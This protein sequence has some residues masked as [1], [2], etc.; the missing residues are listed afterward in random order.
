MA[1]WRGFLFCFCFCLL[2]CVCVC[3]CVCV[4]LLFC[5]SGFLK[6]F[7]C[8]FCCCCV[9]VF[10]SSF[11]LCF[12]CTHAFIC[13]LFVSFPPSFFLSFCLYFTSFSSPSFITNYICSS[14]L[15]IRH[16]SWHSEASESLTWSVFDQATHF[17]QEPN[18]GAVPLS[19]ISLLWFRRGG[20][21]CCHVWSITEHLT[22]IHETDQMQHT[23][24][25]R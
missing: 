18:T 6:S 11:S 12:F 3:M 23:T 4:L 21:G 20:E 19:V 10:S 7:C 22:K 14:I 17:T 5:F 16:K 2:V 15:R 9:V 1:W 8:C 25:W 24:S 13:L